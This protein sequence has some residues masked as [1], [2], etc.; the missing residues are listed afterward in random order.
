MFTDALEDYFYTFRNELSEEQVLEIE[1]VLEN[2]KDFA[3]SLDDVS[4]PIG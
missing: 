3:L 2:C 1:P 4:I